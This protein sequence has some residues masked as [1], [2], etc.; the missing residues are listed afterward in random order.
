MSVCNAGLAIGLLTV[1]TAGLTP[2]QPPR[3]FHFENRQM[4]TLFQVTLYATNEAAAKQAADAAFARAAALDARLSDYKP[5]SELMQLCAR[6]GRGPQ[7]I[8]H[9]LY[10]VLDRAQ[11]ISR[12]TSGAFDVTIGPAVRLWR[13]ARRT[14]EMPPE[15]ERRTALALVGYDKLR[16][17][18][19][20]RTAELLRDNMRLDLGGIAK[21]FAA[22]EMVR[23]LRQSG[24]PVALIAAGG[25]IVAGDAPHGTDGWKVAI[26][27]FGLGETPSRLRLQNAAVSTSGGAEQFVEIAGRRY[28]HIVDPRTGLG[29]TGRMAVTFVAPEGATADAGATAAAVLG[30]LAGVRLAD[31]MPGCAARFVRRNGDTT[32]TT[33]SQRFGKMTKDD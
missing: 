7:E 13:L 24:C 2:A 28:A 16:L 22:D 20:R 17:D 6:A 21:G 9:D 33:V 15:D 32:E 12:R 3:R 4:G 26:A 19:E 1:V 5:D 30:E 11:D 27:P 29:L 10:N 25:D 14:R 23:V 31:S 8:S 18:P